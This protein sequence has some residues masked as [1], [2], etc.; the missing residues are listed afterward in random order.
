ME[1]F[2]LIPIIE[3]DISFQLTHPKIMILFSVFVILLAS[4]C[5]GFQL[6][7]LVDSRRGIDKPSLS[8]NSL[9]PLAVS[10]GSTVIENER[11]TVLDWSFLDGVYLITCP[12]ADPGGERIE[13]AKEILGS[14][15]LLDKLEVKEFA[16]DDENRIRGCYTSH[17]K[18]MKYILAQKTSGKVEVKTPFDDFFG[19][20]K[21]KD[22]WKSKDRVSVAD[23]VN[24][25]ILEDNL[26]LSGGEIK[27]VTIDA[28]AKYS[29]ANP[30]WDMIHLSYIP[31]V[32]D[33]KVTR[34]TNKDIVKLSCGVGSALG[35]TAYIINLKAM[36]T[37]IED[38]SE[39]GGFYAPIP[40]VMAK[41][42]PESRYAVDP[43]MFVRAPDTKSLVN[44]QLDDLR[45]LL[46]RPAVAAF[47][48]R[49]L[50]IT[51]LTTNTLLPS[52]IVLLL[53]ASAASALVT[54]DSISSLITT[55]ELNG[56][57]LFP[58]LS[59]SFAVFSLLVIIKGVMLAPKQG[60]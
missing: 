48:Q 43:T 19:V 21:S 13:K 26:A 44:P 36:R 10:L 39:N 60:D 54:F 52:M 7:S 49:V 23:D 37:V 46:F 34:T 35:T 5:K 3:E 56:P 11:S 50:V 9:K 12:N 30:G 15:G 38:D 27:Q 55:G 14:V 22:A 59:A 2:I 6:N 18:T 58:L 45:S 17:L 53:L 41:L 24:V 20:F 57:I 40:D 28:I 47:A 33:L 51:G 31:Y 8:T 1:E 4:K 25:L 16:T 42:F 32:P 29:S